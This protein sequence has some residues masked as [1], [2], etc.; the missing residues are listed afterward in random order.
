MYTYNIKWI[1]KLIMTAAPREIHGLQCRF[2][3]N[4]SDN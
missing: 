2:I 3:I 1:F 4:N